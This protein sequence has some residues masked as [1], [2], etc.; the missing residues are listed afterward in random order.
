MSIQFADHERNAF[1]NNFLPPDERAFGQKGGRTK[2]SLVSSLDFGTLERAHKLTGAVEW[3][4]ELYQN[5][6]PSGFADTSE[7]SRATY[8][9]IGQYNFTL[10]NRLALS[11]AGPVRP[12]LQVRRRIHLSCSGELSLRQWTPDPRGDRYRR[13]GAGRLR[14]LRFHP[15]AGRLHQ[16]SR[17]ETREI[18]R[19][20]SRCRA[21][22][23]RWHG[24]R[25][26][27][28]LQQ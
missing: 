1:G 13:Q 10:N 4:E 19:L 28:L 11:A 25:G 6:D 23:P 3:E 15:A 9:Y 7:R 18:R 16:Q 14:T 8:S 5:T 24:D 22:L 20:G 12:E 26:R 2:A 17:P 21:D 27:H